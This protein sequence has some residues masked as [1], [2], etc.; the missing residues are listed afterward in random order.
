MSGFQVYNSAGAL[1]IDSDNKSVVM[2]SVKQWVH[3]QTQ[4]TISLTV[5]L[6]TGV[7]WGICP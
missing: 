6:V 7:R 5:P 4:V 2:S 3:S 1:T